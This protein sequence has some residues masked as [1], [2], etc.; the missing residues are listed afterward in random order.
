MFKTSV[1]AVGFV[2][3]KRN[4]RQG[5]QEIARLSNGFIRY[6]KFTTLDIVFSNGI[7]V[8]RW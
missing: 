3:P 7:G 4:T 2:G 5:K 8:T 1:G 6:K